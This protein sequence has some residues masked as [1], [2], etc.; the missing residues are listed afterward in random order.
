MKAIKLPKIPPEYLVVGGVAAALLLWINLRGAKGVGQDIGGATVD[1][2]GGVLT[3]VDQA[4]PE[5]IRPSSTNN[6]VYGS[7][8]TVGGAVSGQGSAWTLGG[9]LYDITHPDPTK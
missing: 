7:I 9:W 2:I 3:G 8:N 4:L 1:L 5:P 6:V